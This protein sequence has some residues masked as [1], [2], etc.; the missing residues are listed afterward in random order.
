MHNNRKPKP[1]LLRAGRD[2]RFDRFFSSLTVSAIE[3]LWHIVKLQRPKFPS[4]LDSLVEA[5]RKNGELSP[6]KLYG[7]WRT[8]CQVDVQKLLQFVA[9]QLN[10]DSRRAEN[11]TSLS[12]FFSQKT[13]YGC[14]L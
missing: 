13:I 10:T 4:S 12:F 8:A 7:S 14:F 5:I 3:N 9:A 2:R 6:W 1:S 11:G